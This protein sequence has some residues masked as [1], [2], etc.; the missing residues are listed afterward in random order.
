MSKRKRSNNDAGDLVAQYHTAAQ[1]ATELPI[2]L[3][4]GLGSTN[5]VQRPKHAE[6]VTSAVT[7]LC[8]SYNR[9]S[10]FAGSAEA[11]GEDDKG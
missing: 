2:F 9:N 4:L 5:S 1:I 6:H 7:V 10:L 11:A 3:D 8:W